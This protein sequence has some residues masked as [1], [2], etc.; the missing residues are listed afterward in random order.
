M[1]QRTRK[2]RMPTSVPV[3]VP[4]RTSVRAPY[5]L[6][7]HDE[8]GFGRHLDLGAD[9]FTEIGDGLLVASVVRELANASADH[10]IG[11]L[12]RRHEL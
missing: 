7:S 11:A 8:L 4:L 2:Q 12:Q 5:C 3:R 9:G 10:K 1:V 6:G